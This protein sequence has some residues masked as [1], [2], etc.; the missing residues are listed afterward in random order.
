MFV[1]NA[2]VHRLSPVKAILLHGGRS[3]LAERLSTLER[4]AGVDLRV[5]VGAQAARSAGRCGLRVR[6]VR[7]A[8][9]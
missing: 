4:R 1:N 7:P 2:E 3:R 8:R 5:F 6:P 9:R